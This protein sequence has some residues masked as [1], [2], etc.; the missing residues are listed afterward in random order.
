[1]TQ[2]TFREPVHILDS[3]SFKRA[4]ASAGEALAFLENRSAAW[5]KHRGDALRDCR[6]AIC[7]DLGAETARASFASYAEAACICLA[8]VPLAAGEAIA[9]KAGSGF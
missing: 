9:R 6:A 3:L 5:S 8:E 1:M 7:G 2:D 4:V